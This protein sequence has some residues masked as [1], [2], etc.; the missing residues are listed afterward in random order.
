MSNV[1]SQAFRSEITKTVYTMEWQ[2]KKG[3]EKSVYEIRY[4]H[5][6]CAE[7]KEKTNQNEVCGEKMR[8]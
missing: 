2:Q 7:K 3:A 8:R 4:D 5:I 6:E 1:R